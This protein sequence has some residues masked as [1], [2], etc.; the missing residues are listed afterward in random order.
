MLDET[1]WAL[2]ERLLRDLRAWRNRQVSRKVLDQTFE[3]PVLRMP[4]LAMLVDALDHDFAHVA[5]DVRSRVG[6]LENLAAL[7]VHDLALLVHHVV[8]LD[9]VL[10]G[11]EM[12]A[13]DFL[14]RA[15][16]RACHPG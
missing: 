12:H 11:I 13:L 16:D 5:E 1:L 6:A 14:L 4:A 2:L 3:V 8:V 9:H 7:L 10:P 15:G